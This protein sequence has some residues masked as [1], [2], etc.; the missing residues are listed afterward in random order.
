MD[1][2]VAGRAITRGAETGQD[3]E[4]DEDPENRPHGV[5]SVKDGRVGK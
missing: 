3:R 4:H 5:T 2:V 1:P